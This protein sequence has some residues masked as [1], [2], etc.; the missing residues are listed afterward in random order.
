M[1]SARGGCIQQVTRYLCCPHPQQLP[2]CCMRTPQPTT[3]STGRGR[4][5]RAP[6]LCLRRHGGP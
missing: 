3:L 6:H 1:V 2:P 5:Q 4:G